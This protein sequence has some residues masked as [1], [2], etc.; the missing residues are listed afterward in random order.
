MA[1]FSK[2]IRGFPQRAA[3]LSFRGPCPAPQVLNGRSWV[4][5]DGAVIDVGDFAQRHPGGSRLITNAVGTDITH[6][7]LG[8][9]LSVGHVMSFNPHKHEEVCLCDCREIDPS[10]STLVT[11]LCRPFESSRRLIRPTVRLIRG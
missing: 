10:L 1:S 6:E 2:G 8:E 11:R 5:V 7:L 9:D 4:M 3:S